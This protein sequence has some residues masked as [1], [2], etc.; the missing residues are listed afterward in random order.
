MHSTL[1]RGRGFSSIDQNQFW[2]QSILESAELSH[3]APVC[4]GPPLRWLL[5]F[6]SPEFKAPSRGVQVLME[7]FSLSFISQQQTD[8]FQMW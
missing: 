4:S 6:M 8:C 1:G 5:L 2:N 3:D 7:T